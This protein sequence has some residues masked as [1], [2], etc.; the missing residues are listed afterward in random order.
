MLS[1]LLVRKAERAIAI[2]LPKLPVPFIDGSFLLPDLCSFPWD[3]KMD[4]HYKHG[5]QGV[6]GGRK[7][8]LCLP[9][10][11]RPLD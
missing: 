5:L 10:V 8:V 11:Q 7:Q 9:G 2:S 6:G 3:A 1:G 4:Q